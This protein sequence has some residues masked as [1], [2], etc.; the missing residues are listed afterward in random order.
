MHACFNTV[1]E[2]PHF[3]YFL[4]NKLLTGRLELFFIHSQCLRGSVMHLSSSLLSSLSITPAF[5]NNFHYCIKKREMNIAYTFKQDEIIL[6]DFDCI[7][8]LAR[9][10]TLQTL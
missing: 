8:L 2:F 7:Q 3:K 1:V 4:T 9:S 6:I 10:L 5:R